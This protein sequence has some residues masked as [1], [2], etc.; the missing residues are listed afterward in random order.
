MNVSPSLLCEL[1]ICAAEGAAEQPHDA[2]LTV[3][4]AVIAFLVTYAERNPDL[5]V[6]TWALNELKRTQP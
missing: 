6:R 4:A 1:L 5:Q 3:P 2:A